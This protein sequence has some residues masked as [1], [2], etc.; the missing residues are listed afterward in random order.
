MSRISQMTWGTMLILVGVQLNLIESFVLTPQATDF[1]N[2]R[3]AADQFETVPGNYV[4]TGNGYFAGS[5]SS[6]TSR[7]TNSSQSSFPFTTPDYQRN[8]Q[9]NGSSWTSPFS[10]PSY[11]SASGSQKLITPP[12]WF[13]WPPIFLGAVLFL[14][15]AASNE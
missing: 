12:T 4:E 5:N 15:G 10:S 6:W 9:S 7:L 11:T 14:F 3:T 1:W 13:C 2:R 8:G